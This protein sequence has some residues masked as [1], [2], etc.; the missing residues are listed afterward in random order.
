MANA[1]SNI[2]IEP[3]DALFGAQNRVTVKAI[4][5]VAGALGGKYFIVSSTDTDYYVWLNTGSSTD[6]MVASKTGI[7]VAITSGNSA[8]VVAS[9]IATEIN[10]A[11][12][13]LKMHASS[14][15]D[16]VTIELKQ[17]GAAKTAAGA[18]TSGFTVATAKTG[19]VLEIG[20]LDGDVE[21]GLDEQLFDVTA[22]QTGTQ[23]LGQ[24]R[25]GVT[26]GPITL[27]LKE[28]VVAKL[29]AIIE[30]GIGAPFTPVA[31]TSPTAVTAVGALAGSKQFGNVTADGG[32]L[33]LHPTKNAATDYS[34]DLAFWLS[35]PKLNSVTFSGEANKA[36]E[37]EFSIFLDDSKQNAASVFVYGD[38]TQNFLK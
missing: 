27:T 25:T 26:A 16:V 14:V 15:D 24:L 12:V 5:D 18:G 36:I 11:D 34:G 20:Y 29:K 8:A 19:F 2:V 9:A 30:K 31:G 33:V 7:E 21:V 17:L 37:V 6:P 3:V 28:A 13:S 22:H 1:V 35:Y 10:S 4:A 38:H 32:K 23:L